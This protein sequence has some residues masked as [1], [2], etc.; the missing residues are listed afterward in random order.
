MEELEPNEVLF[1]YLEEADAQG[2]T[3]DEADDFV[4]AML[5]EELINGG[6]CLARGD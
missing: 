6:R 2:L 3:A 5:A 4:W 1:E